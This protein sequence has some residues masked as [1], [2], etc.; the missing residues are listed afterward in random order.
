MSAVDFSAQIPT[1]AASNE[2]IRGEVFTARNSRQANSRGDAIGQYSGERSGI[3]MGDDTGH[4]PC[5]CGMIGWKRTSSLPKLP[6]TIAV[7]RS[8]SSCCHLDYGTIEETVGEGFAAQKTRLSLVIIV[9]KT[10]P[11][12]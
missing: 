11:K 1:Q 2:H 4:G 12:I 5:G 9:R 6:F 10:P 3:F 8:I 7:C